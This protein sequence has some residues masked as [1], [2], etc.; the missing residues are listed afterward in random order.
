MFGGFFGGGSKLPESWKELT[1][2]DQLEALINQSKNKKQVIFKHS[3]RCSISSMAF[4][5]LAKNW[6]QVEDKGDMHYLDL[7]T[8][9][10]ISNS[11]A[12]KFNVVHQSPQILIIENGLCTK[13][14]SHNQVD[15]EVI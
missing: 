14:A 12:E 8:F 9:R 3:T 5:R 2:L 4:S 7:I 15:V 10:S 13:N 1:T 6:K 11:I